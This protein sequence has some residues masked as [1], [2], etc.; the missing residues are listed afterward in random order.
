M[1]LKEICG[2]EVY[3]VKLEGEIAKRIEYGA[4]LVNLHRAEQVRAVTDDCVCTAVDTGMREINEELRG[5]FLCIAAQLVRVNRDDYVIG[6]KL[7][8]VDRT[9]DALD[10]TRIDTGYKFALFSENEF[11][12]AE[13]AVGKLE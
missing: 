9:L 1:A 11:K 4:I 7:C 13:L 3:A 2:G 10:V 6:L 8:L 5:I 12:V